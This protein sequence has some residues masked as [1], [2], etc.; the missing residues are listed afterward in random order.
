MTVVLT[1]YLAMQLMAFAAWPLVFSVCHRL[2]DRGYGL[3]KGFGLLLVTYI[4]WL[5]AHLAGRMPVLGFSFT[6]I[7]AA[8]A[9]VLL[10]SLVTVTRSAG[11]MAAFL[12][13]RLPYILT[14]EA[15]M[16]AAFAAM[17]ALRAAVPHISYYV[18]N[19]MP[20]SIIDHAAEKFM[21]FAIVNGLL[22]SSH[23]P[24][25]DAWVSG[26]HLNYYYFGHMLWAVLIKFCSVR[27]EIGFNLALAAAGSIAAALAFSLGYNITSRKRW[28]FLALFLIVIS[29]NLDGFWQLLGAIKTAVAPSNEIKNWF[30]TGRPWWRNYDF[31]RS[32]R[33][34]EN[35]INEFPAF[36]LLLG[37]LHA[38]LN[39][40]ILNLCGWTVAIQILRGARQYRS[41][42][43]YERH[44]F[45]ELFFAALIIGALSATNSWDVPIFAGV[46]ALALWSGATGR[47]DPYMYQPAG[48]RTGARLV[49]AGEAITVSA[50]I[51]LVGAG[52]LFY[53]FLRSFQPPMP[54]EGRLIK[55]V[56]ETN[57][58][59][60]FEFVTHW[61]LLGIYPAVAAFAI[62]RR[63]KPAA[64]TGIPGPAS[65]IRALALILALAAGAVVLVP[66]WQ[67]WVAVIAAAVTILLAVA[68]ARRHFPPASRFLIGIL[69]LFSLVVWFDEIFYVDDVFDGPIER[70]NTV[71]KTY[72]SLWPLMAVA[73]IISLRLLIAT[74]RRRRRTALWLI[75]PL[76]IAGAPY[77]VLGTINR[78]TSTTRIGHWNPPADTPT[79][80]PPAAFMRKEARPKNL[81][82]AL[83]GLRYLAFTRPDDYA[84]I[85]WIREN[86]PPDATLLEA[87]GAQ[88]T[89]AGRIST[90]TGR[91]AFDGWLLHS[92]GWR[93]KAFI[94][95][96]DRRFR[97]AAQIY[98]TPDAATAAEM[99]AR[100]DIDYVIVSD[101][102]R[103]QYPLIEEEK[104]AQIGPKVFTRGPLAIYKV[105]R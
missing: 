46:I 50:I 88:Y 54:E 57:R 79:M 52:I 104:F 20:D 21:D 81:T 66:L 30:I 39:A 17:V 37:D 29:S 11:E 72:Y 2:P 8:W 97:E 5:V 99:L 53:P 89:Y 71:F 47:R 98:T 51:T 40:L 76:V 60:P 93:G 7:S 103:E 82:E 87:A 6:T 64:A 91:P 55:M 4:V 63:R 68:L 10:I 95:E 16:L 96:K 45:D 70:I 32:S 19:P 27:P 101:V 26:H 102:E 24:P 23:F 65:P 105:R 74:A 1:W 80:P 43:R 44:A 86:L 13:K 22:T 77:I 92:W 15:V 36:S 31:W 35:T 73:T 59:D 49:R 18:P 61:L 58:T 42:W 69:L 84:A 41:I 34:I 62:L 38:H 94:G 25:H 78:I 56:A 14:L 9:G 67:G 48:H 12:K 85:I 100:N 83:D 75:A 3:A 90:M 33:A 28:G